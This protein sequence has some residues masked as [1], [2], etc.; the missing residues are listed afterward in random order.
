MKNKKNIFKRAHEGSGPIIYFIYFMIIFIISGFIALAINNNESESEIIIPN[1]FSQNCELRV[2]KSNTVTESHASG[3]FFL[4]AGGFNSSTKEVTSY[5]FYAKNN[6][7]EYCRFDINPNQIRV[8]FDTINIPTVRFDWKECNNDFYSLKTYYS[9]KHLL[10]KY[11]SYV[12]ITCKED[13]FPSNIN[14]NEL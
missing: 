1:E 7:N 11:C 2:F 4:I 8:K 14:L 5:Y 13:M 12:V 9:I 3:G 6:D 10:S